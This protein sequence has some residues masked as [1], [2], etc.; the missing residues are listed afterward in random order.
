MRATSL[1]SPQPKHYGL[2]GMLFLFL[3]I[4]IWADI[5]SGYLT[6]RASN[7]Y[8]KGYSLHTGWRAWKRVA[9]TFTF[10]TVGQ[11]DDLDKSTILAAPW[12]KFRYRNSP[13]RNQPG[14]SYEST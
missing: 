13:A 14:H 10:V 8:R 11:A 3:F 1:S 9:E 5:S 7:D 4:C 2:P 6:R 12:Y